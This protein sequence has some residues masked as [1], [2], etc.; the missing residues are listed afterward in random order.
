MVSN[1]FL[2][3]AVPQVLQ[4]TVRYRRTCS[5]SAVC[6]TAFA[7]FFSILENTDAGN[8]RANAGM[9]DDILE[10]YAI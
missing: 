8:E 10:K 2:R 1:G 9:V 7:V 3:P 6:G 5:I 4:N